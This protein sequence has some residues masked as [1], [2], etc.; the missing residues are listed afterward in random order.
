MHSVKRLR[1][2]KLMAR[3]RRMAQ[4]Q[5]L[6]V[7]CKAKGRVRLG[8]Q[9]DHKLALVNGGSDTEDNLQHI[10]DECHKVKTR[11]DLGQKPRP[12][13]GLDGWPVWE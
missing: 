1:G 5:P 3:N 7:R 6:C 9:W 12:K 13:I 2:R 11:Q 8:T 4:A 10:C